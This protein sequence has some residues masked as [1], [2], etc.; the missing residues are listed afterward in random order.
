MKPGMDHDGGY[1]YRASLPR[2]SGWAWA[3]VGK[4]RFSQTRIGNSI[5]L[6]QGPEKFGATTDETGPSKCSRASTPQATTTTPATTTGGA[7]TTPGG[8]AMTP[9][10]AATT[11]GGVVT[12]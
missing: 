1:P 10:G 5:Y 11:P 7:A 6:H 12:T 9:G 4:A 2:K 8:V 3:V